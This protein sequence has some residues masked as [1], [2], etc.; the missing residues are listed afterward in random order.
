MASIEGGDK[1]KKYVD[2][3]KLKL[4]AKDRVVKVGFLEGSETTDG[5][6]L[7]MVAAIQEFGAP[8]AGIPPRPFFRP[9]IDKGSKTWGHDAARIMIATNNDVDL[10]L[11][12]IGDRIRGQLQGA[13][14]DVTAPALSPVTLM[15]RKM[16]KG[17][18]NLRV[19]RTVVQEARA[20]VDRGMSTSGVSTKPL[21]YTG[22]MLNSVDYEV[23]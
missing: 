17:N 16:R 20:R 10:M 12:Q 13:I 23:E 3:L 2:E 4:G 21:V 19:N 15:L 9:T 6:S 7:P 18:G 22:H 11:N 5:V 1:I 14:R 8:A